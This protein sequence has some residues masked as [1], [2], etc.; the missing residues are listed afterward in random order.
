MK[1]KVIFCWSGGKDSA[2]ALNRTLKDFVYGVS[3]VD[4]ATFITVGMLLIGIAAL[5]SVVPAVRAVRL[6]P[7]AALRE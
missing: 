6:N 2:L 7:V 3:T 5:A 1:E 4:L